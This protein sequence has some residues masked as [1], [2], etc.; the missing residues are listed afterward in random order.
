MEKI[1]IKSQEEWDDIPN[2]FKGDIVI[3]AAS[4]EHITISE[5]KGNNIVYDNLKVYQRS[6]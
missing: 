2:N 4:I 1:I 5:Q 3:D 6:H